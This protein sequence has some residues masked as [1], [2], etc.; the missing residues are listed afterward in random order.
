[1]AVRH[2]SIIAKSYPLETAYTFSTLGALY[3]SIVVTLQPHG[4]TSGITYD[5]PISVFDI[6]GDGIFPVIQGQNSWGLYMM[7]SPAVLLSAGSFGLPRKI[8]I[9]YQSG[10]VEIFDDVL[11]PTFYPFIGNALKL[12]GVNPSWINN[13]SSYPAPYANMGVYEYGFN[14][15]SSGA[16][17][18]NSVAGGKRWSG[19]NMHMSDYFTFTK[20]SGNYSTGPG[21]FTSSEI[22]ASY[23]G[24]SNELHEVYPY[25]MQN[26]SGYT[27]LL[28]HEYGHSNFTTLDINHS[29]RQEFRR[30]DILFE[31][32]NLI[33]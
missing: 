31:G 21:T 11:L 8:Q 30:I 16:N 17:P 27:D 26:N 15:D 4:I 23:T 3:T 13:G 33:K 12:Q 5:Q 1:M 7:Y 29:G 22:L 20:Y 6:T 2:H 18:F 10:H 19:S 24:T 14:P 25:M 32:N 9:T 28:A